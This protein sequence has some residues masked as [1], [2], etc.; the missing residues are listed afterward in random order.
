LKNSVTIKLA[1]QTLNLRTEEDADHLQK[2]AHLLDEKIS[3]IGQGS[4]A[5]TQQVA[6]LAGLQIADELSKLKED[7]KTLET[8]VKDR[9]QKSL[10]LLEDSSGKR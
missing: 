1:G 2:V 7:Y 3:E 9:V 8:A 5:S 6:L 4:R 10:S